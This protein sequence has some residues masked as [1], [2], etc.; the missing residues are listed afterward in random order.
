MAAEKNAAV[1]ATA[2]KS[3]KGK[4]KNEDAPAETEKIKAHTEADISE[5][6]KKDSEV[7]IPEPEP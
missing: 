5:N 6:S 4:K 7:V 2:P 3:I 1:E